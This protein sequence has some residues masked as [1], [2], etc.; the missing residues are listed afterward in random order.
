MS[1]KYEQRPVQEN[2]KARWEKPAVREL[3]AGAA[4]VGTGAVDDGDPGT[5]TNNS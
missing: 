5:A 2:P 4:E 1:N 3:R